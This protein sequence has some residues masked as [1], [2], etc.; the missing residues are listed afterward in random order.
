MKTTMTWRKLLVVAIGVVVGLGL[1]LFFWARAVLAGDAVRSTVEAQL[2]QA[3]G[4]PVT[5]GRAGAS[6]LPRV[7]MTL[8][9]VAIGDPARIVVA[10]L[11]VGT[12]FRALLSRRIE[13][14]TLRLA[15]ARLELPLPPLPIGATAAPAPG[16]GL[17]EIV[18][19]DRIELEDVEIVGRG[20]VLRG[21]VVLAPTA[22][23]LEVQRVSLDADGT[24]IDLSGTITDLAGPVGEL[25]ATASVLNV[26]ELVAFASDLSGGFDTG[27]GG[28]PSTAP[29]DAVPMDL[30]IA[31]EAARAT[32]GALALD[33]VS[34]RARL[35]PD[36]ATLS[37]VTFT[38]FG[39]TYSGTLAFTLA[40][41][42]EFRMKASLS[43]IDVASMMAF[44][45][46]GDALAGQLSGTIDVV[47]RGTTADRVIASARGT[48]RVDI[49]HG[50]VA[51]LGL[52]R[53]V[54]LATSM[55][56]DSQAAARAPETRAEPFDT[57]GA[58][59]AIGGGVARTED[60]QF[61]SEDLRLSG[62]GA[63]E[64]ATR[65]VNLVGQ[66]RLSEELSRQ[67]GRDLLRYTRE[68]GRVTLPVIVSGT[69][70]NLSVSL[71]VGDAARRALVNK[72]AEE[73]RKAISRALGRIIKR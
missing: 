13:H 8:H 36:A 41:A 45:H 40:E 56:D 42:P 51:N 64:L 23:G 24:A 55:R 72:A 10:R 47:G 50:T 6:I 12:D 52:V 73:A 57:L 1:G 54:V 69:A 30:Q 15:G 37:P 28:T 27:E 67:A 48:S 35:T 38:V 16:D 68:D 34:G 17:V 61:R 59:F 11:A 25:T 19:V 65:S 26:P 71:D 4:Q 5:I 22:R 70:G 32:L 62:T 33:R 14:A 66:V 3:L 53:T 49:T 2:S 60:L 39:G 20:R 18:S 63:L 7:T 31:I 44:A 21:D 43:D 46:A 29:R 9:D 58:T